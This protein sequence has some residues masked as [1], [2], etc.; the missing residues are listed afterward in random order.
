MLSLSLSTV[1]QRD[2][3]LDVGPLDRGCLMANCY[4]SPH[5]IKIED[6]W[7]SV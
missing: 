5:E 7:L 1:G 3:D 6:F 4:L 2:E